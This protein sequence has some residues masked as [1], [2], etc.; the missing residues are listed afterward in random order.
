MNASIQ[1]AVEQ[2]K[3]SLFDEQ[4]RNRVAELEKNPEAL[5]ECFYKNLEFGTGGMRGIMDVGTNRLNKYTIGLATQALANYINEQIEGE[6]KVVIAYDCRNNNTIFSEVVAQVLSANGIYVYQFP[7]L[8]TTPELSFAVR[9]LGCSAGIVITASHNPPEYNGYKVYWK[10]GGQIVPPHDG[11]I[12]DKFNTLKVSDVKF[13]GN[14]SLMEMLDTSV[15][16]AFFEASVAEVTEKNQDKSAL[17]VVFSSLHGTSITAI[18]PVFEMAGFSNFHVIEEQAKP[19][20]NFPTVESP[21]PEEGAAFAMALKKSDEV[22]A[23]IAIATDPDSDRIGIAVRDL[24]GKMILLNGNQAAA[25]MTDYLVKSWKAEGKI[26]GNQFVGTTIVTSPILKEIASK[27]NVQV[28]EVL[29][30]FKWIADAIACEEGKTKFIGG[31]EESYGYLVGDFV[32]D[33]DAVTSALLLAEIAF[34]KK[35]KGSSLF[36]YLLDIYEEYGLFSE[37]LISIKKAGSKGAAEIQ[38]IIKNLRENP[39]A[40]LG[41][42]KVTVVEDYQSSQKTNMLTKEVSTINLPKSNVLMYYTANGS[43]VAVRPSG[44]EPKIKFYFSVQSA[45][46]N[47]SNYE[48]EKQKLSSRIEKLISDFS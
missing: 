44:T 48:A 36:G 40:E 12:I 15:D 47:K 26:D 46:D 3:S 16:E 18:P 37:H 14:P 17:S 30:G 38:E 32:R 20:G 39:P 33:K 19:D 5:Y 1:A 11:K 25:I 4:T 45:L 31:G 27:N 8:R 34:Q 22:N 42:D 7:D 41:G 28:R 9:H 43:R 21:N 24:S 6:K 29:T 13:E 23:D 2:W 10:D 35:K